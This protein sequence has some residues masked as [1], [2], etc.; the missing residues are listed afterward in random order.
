VPF[1]TTK[2]G[3][4]GIGLALSRQIAEGHSGQISLENRPN[5]PGCQATVELN[6]TSPPVAS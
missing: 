4:S 5:G 3:G 6:L 2:Q 1:F